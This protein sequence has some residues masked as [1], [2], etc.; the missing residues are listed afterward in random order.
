MLVAEVPCAYAENPEPAIPRPRWPPELR[1]RT[2]L[3]GV[4]LPER[5]RT[6]VAF[7]QETPPDASSSEARPGW[8]ARDQ[9][10]STSTL[11]SAP[12]RPLPSCCR[13]P[14][15]PPDRLYCLRRTCC[16]GEDYEGR[17]P[18]AEHSYRSA[19]ASPPSW[20]RS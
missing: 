15:C 12:A 20:R 1:S 9:R 13:R 4:R 10:I 3:R 11:V 7:R 19:R 2:P 6:S 16:A 17:S 14:G 18:V 5:S 8:A